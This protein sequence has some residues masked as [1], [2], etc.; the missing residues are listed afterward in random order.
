MC[1]LCVCFLMKAACN[2]LQT[3]LS[4][5][6]SFLPS[7]LNLFCSLMILL[8]AFLTYSFLVKLSTCASTVL[9]MCV[10]DFFLFPQWHLVDKYAL[11][12]FFQNVSAFRV[13]CSFSHLLSAP[14]F[15]PHRCSFS[16]AIQWWNLSTLNSDLTS[17]HIYNHQTLFWCK[18]VCLIKKQHLCFCSNFSKVEVKDLRFDSFIIFSIHFWIW[19]SKYFSFA[20]IIHPAVRCAIT[21]GHSEVLSLHIQLEKMGGKSKVL[22]LYFY[23]VCLLYLIVYS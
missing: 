2:V 11:S 13:S 19:F 1:I 17:F 3:G 5:L 10:R 23:W 6:M 12:P 20:E 15:P 18:S 14:F 16:V 7:P 4:Y 22:H 21:R 9:F 8:L